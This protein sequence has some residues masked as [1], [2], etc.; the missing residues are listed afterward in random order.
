MSKL[1]GLE[2]QQVFRYFEDLCGIPHGSGNTKGVSDYCAAFAR[3]HGLSCIQDEMN[4]IIIVKEA[5]KGYEHAPAV[6]LQGHLDMVAVKTHDCTL[7]MEKDGLQL[8]VD[9][10]YVSADGTSLGG[11]NGIAVA[12]CLALL[13]AEDLE[14]PRLECIFTVDEEIGLLGAVGLD[15]SSLQG[16]R[17]INL[18]SEEE[19]ILTV[20]CAGGNTAVSTLPVTREEK[21]GL[22]CKLLIHGCLGGH[23]GIEIQKERANPNKLLARFLHHLDLSMGYGL[24]ALNGGSKDNAIPVKAEA[25]LLICEADKEK[26]MEAAAE[27][28]AELANEYKSND[29]DVKVTLEFSGEETAAVF[30]AKSKALAIYLLHIVPNGVL[31]NSADIEGLVQTSL[32]LGVLTT[33]EDC[34]Q[35]RFCVR[36]S[37]ASEQ[38]ALNE[39]L[40]FMSEFAGGSFEVEGSYG[41][42]EYNKDS[43][44]RELMIEVYEEMYGQKPKV[45]AIHAGLECGLFASKIEG[46]DCISIGPDMTHV[47]TTDERLSIS[48]TKRTWEY[49]V[50]VLKRM[51]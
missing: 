38:N 11:D 22:A 7:D 5:T 51:K 14:H 2:P 23:S 8:V 44:L 30:T 40:E 45:E 9:G 35:M 50:N 47:H 13:A 29:P 6:I 31:R 25:E 19:G 15:V 33:A 10:D 17:L 21:T 37:V 27:F 20:S 49:L 36:S 34:V 4:N 43:E 18:D 32:N 3:E 46:L 28:G 12:Y 41:G 48:S 16:K 39:Q 26:L 24:K 42:W 1:A